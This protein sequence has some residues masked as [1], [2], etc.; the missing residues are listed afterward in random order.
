MLNQKP[1]LTGYLDAVTIQE[2]MIKEQLWAAQIYSGE[3]L[4]AVD[5]NENLEYVIPK[6]GAPVWVDFFAI[7]RDARHKEEAHKFLNYILRPEV[8]ARIASYLWYAT[9][10]EAAKPLMD[11]EILECRSVYPSEEVMGRCEYFNMIEGF[12]ISFVNAIWSDLT[13]NN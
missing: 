11:S 2:K 7:P 3:A 10:N 12:T 9:P 6:E 8:N 4:D 13:V 5:N 1:L